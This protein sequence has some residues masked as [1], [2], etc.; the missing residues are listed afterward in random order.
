MIEF[1]NPLE[2]SRFLFA[3]EFATN[4]EGSVAPLNYKKNGLEKWG[5]RLVAPLFGL[6]NI[7]G[8]NIQNPTFII[9]STVV[10]LAAITL[11]FYPEKFL[12]LVPKALRIAPWVAKASFYVLLQITVLGIGLRALGRMRNPAVVEAHQ[13]KNLLMIP[14]GAPSLRN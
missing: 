13:Q 7:V 5:G 4:V 3:R 10:A 8:Q 6:A 1:K 2:Y 11:F 14:I 9:A 12:A